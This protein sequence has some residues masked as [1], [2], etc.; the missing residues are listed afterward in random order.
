MRID[1]GSTFAIARL[2]RAR[3]ARS[4]ALHHTLVTVVALL[5]L[6]GATAAPAAQPAEPPPTD[7]AAEPATVAQRYVE[8]L[9]GE[10]RSG[11]GAFHDAAMKHAMTADQVEQMLAGLRS[12]LG[13]LE[14]I[15]EAWFEDRLQGYTRIRVPLGFEKGEKGKVDAR[16]V[17]DGESR[18]S[19][20][21][22]VPRVE[23]PTGDT[24]DTEEAPG[25][26]SEVEVGAG[27][28][29]LPGVL[30]R[31]EGEGPFPAVVLVHGSGPNDRDETIG[32]NK[33]L[34]DLAWG[35][36]ERGI[37]SLRYDKRSFAKP[38]TLTE[39]GDALTVEHEVIAD[40]RAALQ[41]LAEAPG[42]DSSRLF[43]VGHSLGGTVLPRI[44][45]QELPVAGLVVLAGATRPL[46]EKVIEQT[47][48]IAS[49]QPEP[50][51]Q[52]RAARKRRIEQ[53]V[54]TMETIR[55]ALDGAIE[56]PSGNLMGAPIGY[57]RDLEAHPPAELAEQARRPILVLQG[58]RDYQVTMEDFAI[59]RE[60]LEDEPFACLKSYPTLDHLLR[61][62]EG[63]STPADYEVAAPMSEQLISDVAAWI[64]DGTCPSS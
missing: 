4:G 19:G 16:V 7:R 52:Q 27:D 51:E 18:V 22:F 21:F 11:L 35:L 59:W 6:T 58:E 49:Q 24:A 13:E 61:E 63:P 54:E 34:R 39:L 38:Q 8:T 41:V 56:P 23:P 10:D 45:T 60:A 50:S 31:P 64:L 36:A 20:L 30:L 37:A 28:D 46:P 48:Y 57:Y 55:R 26:E 62:G 9:F 17:I 44:P 3:I 1:H 33:P 14:S 25:A 15:G 29:A 47:R 40:A 2:D 12:Q 42:I 53:V 43:L 5:A 32:P